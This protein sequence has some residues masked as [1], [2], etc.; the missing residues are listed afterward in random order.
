VRR[1]VTF[2]LLI[3]PGLAEAQG[4]TPPAR[5][6]QPASAP[7]VPGTADGEADQ[8]AQKPAD[9]SPRDPSRPTKVTFQ[10]LH[11]LSTWT[12]DLRLSRPRL[13]YDRWNHELLLVES[14]KLRF[15]IAS[16]ME[17]YRLNE[18][19]ELGQVVDAAP[20]RD[21]S[22]VLLV[23]QD[24]RVF[25]LLTNF[26][27][28]PQGEV[29]L[30]ALPWRGEGAFSPSI[31]VSN[32]G[33]LYLLDQSTMRLAVVTPEGELK[34][35]VELRE[36]VGEDEKG[37]DFELRGLSVD[38]RGDLLFVIPSRFKVHR[39]NA[40]GRLEG[41][42]QKGDKPGR[43]NVVVAAAADDDG[44][45]FVSDPLKGTVQ[46]FDRDFKFVD[47]IKGSAARDSRLGAVN[48]VVVGDGRLYV[49]QGGN[50]GVAVFAI[51]KE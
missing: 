29:P 28:E 20:Q 16:G 33:L 27:G 4:W 44:V 40:E 24:R 22:L 9:P 34:R 38:T 11:H 47:A 43:F 2:L 48:E 13:S 51:V 12:G 18:G 23:K 6:R 35:A 5:A 45:I 31:M 49:S 36:L 37:G 14:G 42:G 15:F 32:D 26:R 10:Y 1:A 21:G 25:P 50:R 17:V 7:A 3:A 46:V 39:F 30:H 8:P 19:Y 41:F